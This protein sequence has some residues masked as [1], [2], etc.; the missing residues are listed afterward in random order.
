MTKNMIKCAAEYVLGGKGALISRNS[1]TWE[2]ICA[3]I[4]DGVF[5]ISDIAVAI[6]AVSAIPE[7][8]YSEI[9]RALEK[10]ARKDRENEQ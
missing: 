3:M 9:R 5:S 1:I 10:A 6:Y 8:R 2:R 7:V 4:K